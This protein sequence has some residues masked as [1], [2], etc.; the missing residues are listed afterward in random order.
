MIAPPKGQPDG[1]KARIQKTRL[2]KPAG[3]DGYESDPE[4]WTFG[5]NNISFGME[6]TFACELIITQ[7]RAAFFADLKMEKPL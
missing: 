4:N 5:S 6:N 7:V 1:H 2:L 3:P